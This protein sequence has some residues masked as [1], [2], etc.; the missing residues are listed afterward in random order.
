MK[1]DFNIIHNK[2]RYSITLL[3]LISVNNKVFEKNW[4]FL[5]LLFT[6]KFN[7]YS[8]CFKPTFINFLSVNISFSNIKAKFFAKLDCII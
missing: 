6:K 5:Y 4:D 8:K 7:Y 3:L 1:V 2:E